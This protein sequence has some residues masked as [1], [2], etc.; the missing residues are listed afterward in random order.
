MKRSMPKGE[1][2]PF[3]RAVEAAGEFAQ[4]RTEMNKTILWG[5]VGLYGQ[6]EQIGALTITYCCDHCQSFPLSECTWYLRI[7]VRQNVREGSNC[8]LRRGQT[9]DWKRSSRI[10]SL[11]ARFGAKRSGSARS[12]H[13]RSKPFSPR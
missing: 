10:S 7:G 5:R 8:F 4:N 1:C 13:E 12:Q 2:V 3:I 11:R 6:T 9:F